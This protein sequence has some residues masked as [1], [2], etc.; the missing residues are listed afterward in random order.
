MTAMTALL[1]ED[2]GTA[3]PLQRVSSSA[4][5]E[6]GVR[7]EPLLSC[8]GLLLPILLPWVLVVVGRGICVVA[9]RVP[10]L[11]WLVRAVRQQLARRAGQV[12]A[13]APRPS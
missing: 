2:A 3:T 11:V 9:Q 7:V 13:V 12:P 10:P 6:A 1:H 4:S 8:V 5:R